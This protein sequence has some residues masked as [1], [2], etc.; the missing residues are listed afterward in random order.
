MKKM[1]TSF[2]CVFLY[3]AGR[4]RALHIPAYPPSHPQ[5]H[6]YTRTRTI[7]TLPKSLKR[8]KNSSHSYVCASVSEHPLPH[9]LFSP[10]RYSPATSQPNSLWTLSPDW[11]EEG[12]WSDL[13][14]TGFKICIFICEYIK[15]GEER[16]MRWEERR[17]RG[18]VPRWEELVWTWG[19]G[20]EECECAGLCSGVPLASGPGGGGVLGVQSGSI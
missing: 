8:W 5:T 19:V 1:Y 9:A 17:G 3:K 10:Q 18:P 13:E 7:H 14:K 16:G 2:F 11:Q 12:Q 15:R 4:S 6:T 20:G